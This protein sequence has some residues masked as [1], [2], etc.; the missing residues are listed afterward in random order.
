[1]PS[2]GLLG[3]R[4]MADLGFIENVAERLLQVGGRFVDRIAN[5]NFRK[6]ARKRDAF[7]TGHK[8]HAKGLGVFLS[9][10][11]D[12]VGGPA[13][14]DKNDRPQDVFVS[15]LG[16]VSGIVQG[17]LHCNVGVSHFEAYLVAA[18]HQRGSTPFAP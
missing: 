7:G 3:R 15:D 2:V 6:A 1:M 17:H 18:T 13:L 4:Q 12:G 8:P 14:Y 11:E 5:R 9:G 10:F 16:G